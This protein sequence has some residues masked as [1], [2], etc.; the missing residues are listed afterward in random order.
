MTMKKSITKYVC[1]TYLIFMVLLLITGGVLLLSDNPLLLCIL[2]NVCSWAPTF[3]LLLLLPQLKPG[4]S[5]K[6]FLRS[7]F[8]EK[9]N[10]RNIT[11]IVGMQVF[12]FAVTVLI[13]KLFFHI[14]PQESLHFSAGL[15]LYAVINNIT[16]GAVGEEAGWSGYLH[17]YF[18]SHFGVVRGSF[19]IGLIWGFWHTPLWFITGEFIGWELV[20]YIICFLIYIISTAIIIG[21]AYEKN[22][23]LIVP[24]AI[25]FTAN[26]LMA[27]VNSEILLT[28]LTILAISYLFGAV[29]CCLFKK[30]NNY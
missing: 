11:F 10:V 21:L 14:E 23:N 12:L 4:F 7:L 29:V 30:M 3:S 22:R 17:P 24:M 5:R 8:C 6:N 2:K 28:F 15:L 20:R 26:F 25:H 16:S 19:F 1:A 27:F 13:L 18:V 9:V